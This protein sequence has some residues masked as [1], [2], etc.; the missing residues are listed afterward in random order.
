M[1]DRRSA[2][3]ALIAV[4]LFVLVACLVAFF[5]VLAAS[6]AAGEASALPNRAGARLLA[7]EL[8]EA[9]R[10]AVLTG[11]PIDVTFEIDASGH[12]VAYRIAAP[13]SS[14]YDYQF[15]AR[16]E[17]APELRVACPVRGYRLLPSGR[18]ADALTITLA[19]GDRAT[20]VKITA[21]GEVRIVP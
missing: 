11:Q 4:D 3:R 10:R 12:C 2:V 14:R 19:Q 15:V 7:M 20:L 17:F 8:F 21:T 16:R 13:R 18:P 1:S 5:N 9:Q 6:L